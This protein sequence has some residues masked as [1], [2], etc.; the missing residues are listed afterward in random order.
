M[1]G[2]ASLERLLAESASDNGSAAAPRAASR[3]WRSTRPATSFYIL[4]EG[5][6][7]GDDNVSG[8]V[9][10]NLRIDEFDIKTRTYTR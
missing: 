9:G 1:A 7:T 3:A 10:K 5:T 8:I 6:V 2:T 4:L